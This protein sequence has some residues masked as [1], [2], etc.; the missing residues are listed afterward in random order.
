MSSFHKNPNVLWT[1]IDGHVM[2]MSV[3]NG[4]Y[5]ELVGVADDIWRLLDTKN[6]E[7]AIVD[8]LVDRFDVEREKCL[9]DVMAFLM[10]M[11]ASNIIFNRDGQEPLSERLVI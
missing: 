8:A 9:L 3:D 4:A 5:F 11:L 2:I 1:E 10:K 7:D 6:D